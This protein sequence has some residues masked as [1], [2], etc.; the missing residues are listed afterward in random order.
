MRDKAKYYNTSNNK[1]VKEAINGDVFTYL[2]WEKRNNQMKEI[3]L[4]FFKM[5]EY[6]NYFFRKI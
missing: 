3:L 4:T 6:A 5:I 2:D 1:Y